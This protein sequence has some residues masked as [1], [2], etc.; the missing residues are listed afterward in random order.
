MTE[1]M[2][3]FNPR[4]P[5]YQTTMPSFGIKKLE[6][7][8]DLFEMNVKSLQTKNGKYLLLGRVILCM[9]PQTI[10]KVRRENSDFPIKDVYG[11]EPSYSKGKVQEGEMSIDDVLIFKIQI[12]C[13]MEKDCTCRIEIFK[14]GEIVFGGLFKLQTQP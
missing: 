14:G 11:I 3:L 12:K 8:C 4:E 2:T 13:L 9:L 10:A 1:I 6:A 7:F 5:I